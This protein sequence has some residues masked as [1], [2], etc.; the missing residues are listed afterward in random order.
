M[1]TVTSRRLLNIVSLA[2]LGISI[3]FTIYCFH[4][5][6]FKNTAALQGLVSHAEFFGPLLFIGLQIVQV[7][8]PIIP[9]GV[10]LAAG[11]LIFGPVEGFVYNYIGIV[12]GSLVAF[13]LG[14][15]FGTPLI[16][17]LIS[18]KTYDRYIGRITNQNRF[19]KLFALAIFLP[20]APDD[21]LCLLAGLTKMSF[22]TFTLII[23]LGK[24]ASILAYSYVLVYGGTFLA[25]LI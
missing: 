13:A 11:V 12:L 17:H 6:V 7:V 5:G 9:G 16:H 23:L 24:P 10:S 21:V 15:R 4:L 18:Q 22:K 8:I 2:G 14:R 3:W 1:S 20:V 25:H 19:T